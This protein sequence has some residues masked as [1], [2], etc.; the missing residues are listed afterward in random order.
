[1]PY[2]P[3]LVW[4]LLSSLLLWLS[5]FPYDLGV[6]GWVAL[7]P[8]MP[9]LQRYLEQIQPARAWYDRPLLSAWLGGLAFCLVAFQW[10]RL[11]S[12][13]MYAT[14]IVLAL[15]VSG[16][17][18]P[19][20]FVLTRLLVRNVNAPL[21]LAAPLTWTALEYARSQIYIGFA[22]Y[23]L[24]HTQHRETDFSQAASLVG[25][26]GLSFMVV[27]VSV[28]MW[29]TLKIRTLRVV[30]LELVPAV[31]LVGLASWY[32][33]WIVDQDLTRP[34]QRM[35]KPVALLQGNQPQDLRNTQEMWE[36]IDKV[37]DQL[38][39]TAARSH[40][41]LI[42]A[43]ETCLSLT[44]IRLKDDRLPERASA[45]LAEAL[46]RSQK[47]AYEHATRWNADILLG[48]NTFDFSTEPFRHTNSAILLDRQGREVAWYDKIVC[49]PF[50]EYVPL[51]D[52]LPFM[53][54]LSPYDYEY[55]IRPGTEV[56]A[57]RWDGQRIGV[58]ICYEDT[59]PGLVRRFMREQSPDFFANLSNDGW[60][61]G[62][63]EHEQHLVC[64]RFRCIETHRS[65]VRAV[66]MGISCII[67]GLGRVITLPE[68]ANTWG[69][70][71]D[72]EAVIVGA[73]PLY[74]E[75]TYYTRW[76]DLLPWGGWI[77][78]TASL[79]LSIARRAKAKYAAA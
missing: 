4:C 6:L 23:F 31:V 42:I 13:P 9:V 43:P 56:K 24:G 45:R 21:L 7:I 46:D 8:I 27:M 54:W 59:V 70:A 33:S 69:E 74:V 29:R 58:L 3:T 10:I 57:V 41:A 25:V 76:G 71:K 17:Q 16:L 22:W 36:K 62:S 52:V 14:W 28:G 77:I 32:G 47:W 11:A 50:G 49:L 79:V 12:P 39:N 75:E 61:K 72:R 38:G 15:A 68:G 66:N 73:I 78:I 34:A 53:R 44:W 48:W 40:P 26:Y 64:A 67:D 37:Y 51:G 63:E 20:F 19:L 55:T 65:M 18:W 35:T 30:C 2:I 60:F 1:M 5:F